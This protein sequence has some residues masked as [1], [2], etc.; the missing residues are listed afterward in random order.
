[1]NE[2]ASNRGG[3]NF[4][5]QSGPPGLEGSLPYLRKQVDAYRAQHPGVCVPPGLLIA[6]LNQRLVEIV[7]QSAN[8][9]AASGFGL[10][11]L[12]LAA[13]D[14]A[15]HS[16]REI[17]VH[18]TTEGPELVRAVDRIIDGAQRFFEANTARAE[19]EAA[20]ECARALEM[21]GLVLLTKYGSSAEVAN[22]Q[23]RALRTRLLGLVMRPA[24][25]N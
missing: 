16:Y 25:W 13:V 22:T 14:L 24:F 23:L 19:R 11:H 9:V 4:V 6:H 7:Q 2:Y 5:N 21:Y 17:S 15:D 20:L 3:W 12:V 8:R 1:M 10:T 18:A